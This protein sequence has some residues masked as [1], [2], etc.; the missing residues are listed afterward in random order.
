MRA[1]EEFHRRSY[2]HRVKY[3]A[4]PIPSRWDGPSSPPSIDAFRVDRGFAVGDEL[5]R[6]P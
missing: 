5:E 6:Q 2:S 4:Y 3:A 1:V